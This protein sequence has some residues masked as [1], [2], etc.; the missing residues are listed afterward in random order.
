MPFR[1]RS[2]HWCTDNPKNG[3]ILLSVGFPSYRTHVRERIRIHIGNPQE[4][5]FRL[6]TFGI[7]PCSV[8][9]NENGRFPVYRHL[10]WIQHH[11]AIKPIIKH[12]K[13]HSQQKLFTKDNVKHTALSINE[14][15][16]TD[17]SQ[18]LPKPQDVLLGAGISH[19]G[20]DYFRFLIASQMDNYNNA[21]S[22]FNKTLLS[23]QIISQVKESG[24]RF[25]KMKENYWYIVNDEEV[26]KKVSSSFRNQRKVA[27][28]C[29]L[30]KGRANS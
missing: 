5:S 28:R 26:R 24:G 17:Y 30:P 2:F 9:L 18:V 25:L 10:E 20:N 3:N 23:L 1:I 21:D 29:N 16:K 7:Q 14:N 8:L 22:S 12:G 27:A 15:I 6:M 13:V 4:C 19:P 11:Q